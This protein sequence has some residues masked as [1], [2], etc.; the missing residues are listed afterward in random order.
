MRDARRYASFDAT[1]DA[2][3]DYAA[4]ADDFMSKAQ[5]KLN[6]RPSRQPPEPHPPHLPRPAISGVPVGPLPPAR[7]VPHA[8]LA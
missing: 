3:V 4:K 1:P 7:R 5:K 6:V 2:M 8:I